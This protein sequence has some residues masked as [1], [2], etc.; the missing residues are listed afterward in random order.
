M[1]LR[2]RSQGRLLS[3]ACF[4][5]RDPG[6]LGMLKQVF[7]AHFEPVVT[8]LGPWNIPKCLE[9]GSFRDQKWVK[10]GEKTHFSKS[11]PGPFR[12]LGQAFLA[13]FEPIRTGF[14]Q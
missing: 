3:E 8:C 13:H 11:H 1:L 9:N 2:S 5:K 7:L 14:G 12:M 4:S 6:P 10:N